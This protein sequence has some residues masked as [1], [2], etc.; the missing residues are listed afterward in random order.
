MNIHLVSDEKFIN[1]SFET[2][3]YYF[4]GKNLFFVE[5]GIKTD[6]FR[7]VTPRQGITSVSLFRPGSV[8]R[9]FESTPPHANVFV[10]KLS[11]SKAFL[12]NYLKQQKK[13]RTYWLLYGATL[14]D[15]LNRRR[16]FELF[17]LETKKLMHQ[18]IPFHKRY[19]RYLSAQFGDA[20]MTQFIRGLNYFCFWNYGDYLLLKENF[21]T[22][23]QWKYFRYFHTK[24]GD[25]VLPDQSLL[26]PRQIIVNHSASHTGN[27]LSILQRL[28]KLDTQQQLERVVTPLSYGRNYIKNAVLNYGTTNLPYCFYPLTDMLP[29]DAYFNILK[30]S[31]SAI[32]GHRRQEAGNNIY[33]LLANGTKVFLRKQNNLLSHL[34]DKGYTVFEFEEDLLHFPAISLLEEKDR[35]RNLALV[36]EEFSEEA[37]ADTYENLI[38][39]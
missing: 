28:K 35:I 7:F 18:G 33:F 22:D 30:S 36:K 14:Y 25:K 8:K 2:F 34:K 39:G 23:A 27:H 9:L 3:E 19:S 26:N 32:F 20:A 4:P 12:V 11:P 17:D 1:R 29:Q 6:N 21:S 31:G 5:T 16:N 13:V 15:L 37:I 10:H 38:D 24:L